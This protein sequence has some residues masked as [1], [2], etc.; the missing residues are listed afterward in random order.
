MIESPDVVAVRVFL[1]RVQARVAMRYALQGAAVGFAFAAALE[2]TVMRA[3]DMDVVARVGVV[4]VCAVI[5]AFTRLTFATRTR[6]DAARMIER[7]APQCRNVL[8][9][10]E[11]LLDVADRVKPNV[12][13]L[14]LMQAARIV[15]PLTLTVLV[16]I[17]RSLIAFGTAI[18]VWLAAMLLP[19]PA[20]IFPMITRDGATVTS[21]VRAVRVLITPPAYSARSPITLRDPVRIDALVGSTIALTVSAVAERV[22][23]ETVR[24]THPLVRAGSQEYMGSVLV[25]VDGF[26]AIEPVQANGTPGVKRLIGV[27]VTPDHPPHVRI[28]VPGHDMRFADANRSLALTVNADDDFGLASLRVRY[29]KVSGSGERFTFTDGEIPLDIARR[30]GRTWTA[31]GRLAL[32]VLGLSPGDLVVYRASAGDRRPGA[33]PT[34]SDSYIAEIAAPGGVAASGFAIDNNQDRYALS[35]QMVILKTQQLLAKR[36]TLNAEVFASDAADIATEQR[37]V[38]AEF[39]FM[40]GGEMA[41]EIASDASMT[42]LNETREA[43]SEGDLAAGRMANQGRIALLRA[44]RNMSRASAALTTADATKAL[45]YEKEALVQIERAFSRTRIILR[46]LTEREKLDTTRRLTGVLTTVTRDLRQQRAAQPNMRVAALRA[47]LAEIAAIVNAAPSL[48]TAAARVSTLAQRVLQIDASSQPLQDIATYLTEAS[49]EVSRGRVL[50]ANV[51]FD[52][53]ALGLTR[54]L[55]RDVLSA[56]STVSSLQLQ[57]LDGDLVQARKRAPEQ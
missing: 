4:L 7:V 3:H 43:E 18:T 19:S 6:Q 57:S 33:T 46:A 5:S 38:R 2:A 10:A 20:R 52:R 27:S 53:A 55:R 26:I 54:V 8:V 28:S 23:V 36:T 14:V 50:T 15:R 30:D 24:G 34:E 40:M 9:T 35:E 37:R 42:D 13:A 21:S 45:G 48:E 51:L 41:E 22:T 1:S 29:T 17:H 31:R 56:P 12:S 47:A 11:E 44:I 39:V 25:D 32:D 49:S 16:P